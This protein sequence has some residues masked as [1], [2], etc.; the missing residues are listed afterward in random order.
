MWV[1]GVTLGS[2]GSLSKHL[3]SLSHPEGP[4]CYLTDKEMQIPRGKG[5]TARQQQSQ[6]LKQILPAGLA[7]PSPTEMPEILHSPEAGI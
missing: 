4:P 7:A 1:L 5:L 3:Y 6:V 2:P